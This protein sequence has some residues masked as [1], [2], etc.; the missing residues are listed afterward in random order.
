M[1]H[2]AEDFLPVAELA[3]LQRRGLMMVRGADRPL[4]LSYH[5]GR[6]LA[7]D[8][9]CPHL[10]FPLHQGTVKDGIVTCHW[11]H[12]RFDACSGCAFDLFADDVPTFAVKIDGGMVCVARHPSFT[13]DRAYYQRRLHR[14]LEQAISLVQTKSIIGLMAEADGPAAIV[15]QIAEFGAA[16]HE[17]WADGM[18]SLAVATRLLPWLDREATIHVL[19]RAASRVADN[20]SRGPARRERS[21]MAGSQAS[22]GQLKRWL[23][24]WLRSRERDAAERTLLTA[25]GLADAPAAVEDL[26]F[27]AINDRIYS[28]NGHVLDFA[29]KACELLHYLGWDHAPQILPTLLPQ[30]ARAR[31]AEESSAWRDPVDLVDLVRQAEATLANLTPASTPGAMVRED[32]VDLLL[33][34]DA[35]ALTT[36]LTGELRRGVPPTRLAQTVA[37]AAARRLAHF[38]ET[39]D[40]NDWFFPM[41]TFTYANAVHQCVVRVG[42]PDTVRGIFH[43]AL[44]IY[45]DRFLNVPA[46]RLP[47]DKL[48]V[49]ATTGDAATRLARLPVLLDRVGNLAPFAAHVAGYIRAGHDLPPLVNA[50]ALLVVREDMDFHH[51]QVLEAGA[52]QARLWWGQPEAEH[53]MAGV[54]RSL[55]AYCPTRRTAVHITRTALRLHRGKVPRAE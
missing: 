21:A 8:D 22:T 29:N 32:L 47:G 2:P 37:Y 55:A 40:G 5:D 10:G 20:C 18:T 24:D 6:V 25:A 14:G 17:E 1:D 27:A 33:G 15:R 44:A 52:Q 49:E 4:A 31:G 53:I 36:A 3:E 23:R 38:P 11:H 46:A 42:T 39:N 45:Q 9:R 30:L 35:A 50:L 13:A 43:A 7:F 12:A 34:D 28:A 48:P 16:H 41:H 54:A 51:L 26:L 19:A